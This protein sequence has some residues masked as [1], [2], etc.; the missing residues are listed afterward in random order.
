MPAC[1]QPAHSL[2]LRASWWLWNV[3]LPI[4]IT[5]QREEEEG[6]AVVP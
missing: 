1:S 5:G 6:L 3:P 4:P 2:C